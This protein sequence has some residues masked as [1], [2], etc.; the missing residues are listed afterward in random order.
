MCD[1]L[2]FNASFKAVLWSLSGQVYSP[3]KSESGKCGEAKRTL[4]RL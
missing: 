4:N 2:F 3:V 1:L